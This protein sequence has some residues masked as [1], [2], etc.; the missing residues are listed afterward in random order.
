MYRGPWGGAK[1]RDS[2]S[3]VQ[4]DC[5]CSP[6]KGGGRGVGEGGGGREEGEGR[7]EVAGG[8]R[9]GERGEMGEEEEKQYICCVQ[10]PQDSAVHQRC[11]RRSSRMCWSI[12][13]PR[14]EWLPSLLSPFRYVY[15]P[16]PPPPQKYVGLIAVVPVFTQGRL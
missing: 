15:V 11:I 3:Q 1:C 6:G 14:R 8:G 9:R 12:P 4:R 10:S 13:F 7:G 5:D 2:I 16:S